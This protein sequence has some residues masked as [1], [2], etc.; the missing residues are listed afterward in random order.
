DLDH[1]LAG[2]EQPGVVVD[3]V[4]A[5]ELADRPAQFGAGPATDGA[6]GDISQG[7][8][9][10]QGQQVPALDGVE[11]GVPDGH[12]GHG[13]GHAGGGSPDEAPDHEAHE[14]GQVE[15]HRPD[16]DRV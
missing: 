16:L 13:G 10:Q 5:V 4:V 14:H 12:V 2:V 1:E 11:G 15:Q 9:Q 7:A 8:G 3:A 6:E